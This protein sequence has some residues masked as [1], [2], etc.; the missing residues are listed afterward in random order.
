MI[1]SIAPHDWK[2]FLWA[3]VA[4]AII[5]IFTQFGPA[6]GDQLFSSSTPKVIAKSEAESTAK[7]FVRE[8]FGKAA[9]TAH[10][11]YQTDSLA[12]GYF[13][14]EELLGKFEDKYDAKFPTDTF[15]VN[16]DLEDGTKAYVYVHMTNGSITGWHWLGGQS[17]GNAQ[18]VQT[19]AKAFAETKGFR[20]EELDSLYIDDQ[21][22]AV[23][24]PT[25]YTL[26][27]ASLELIIGVGLVDDKAVIT[28]YKPAFQ[29]P[30]DYVSYVEGQKK[31]GSALSVVSLAYMCFISLVLSL[32]YA[33][34]YRGHTTFKRGIFISLVFIVFYIY[35]NLNV[36]DGIMATF[37]EQ[38]RSDA[39]M[40]ATVLITV[41]LLIPVGLAVYFA[42]VA[43]DGMWRSQKR[44]LWPGFRER[45]YGEHVWRSVGLSYLFAAIILGAQAI[46]MV[47]MKFLAGSWA[48]SDATQ[49]PYNTDMLWL[50]PMM[51]WCAAISEEAIFRL[52]GIALFKKWFKNTFIATLIPTIMWALGHVG[53]P[54]FPFYTRIV[55]LVI[56]GTVFCLIFLRYGFI[57]AVFTH[58]I[59]D[60]LIMSFELVSVGGGVNITAA[61]IYA[62]LP[63]I[64]AWV[65]KSWHKRRTPIRV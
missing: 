5:F 23:L 39:E 2:R 61:L 50:M 4:G 8:Q 18:S 3:A 52:F 60:S 31:T 1:P 56:L 13:S 30:A 43:G 58:A 38:S 33:I 36:L 49:S 54:I 17:S 28:R 57:T 46:I 37:G 59:L 22:D 62:I 16:L 14:K 27:D 35:N 6:A 19:S 51:A 34:L 63:V 53:Y 42:L 7:K 15:Q 21:G 64:I 55:E 24:H 26:G 41:V 20:P 25:G 29:A 40:K 48:T 32:I 47:A 45:G 44:P 11:I 10:T 12:N 65:I 9:V